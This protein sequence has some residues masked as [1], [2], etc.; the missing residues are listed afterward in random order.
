MNK[1]ALRARNLT[2]VYQKIKGSNKPV[3][4][5]NKL[6]LE[7]EQGEI[8]GLLG[9]NGAG[10]TT[11]VDLM[12]RFY[13]VTSGEI[14]IDGINVKDI[15]SG[16]DSSQGPKGAI[17]KVKASTAKQKRKKGQPIKPLVATGMMRRLPPIK[18]KSG[19][20]TISLA[21]QRVKIAQYHEQGAGNLPKREFFDIYPQ[22]YRKIE[23]MLK[24]KLIKLFS[25]L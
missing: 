12:P 23:R 5:L 7:V 19:K 21:N 16:L 6:N 3:L 25:K 20:S 11:F 4:A 2:K 1:I 24:K 10:K 17:K 22:T 18:N 8:F 9:P 14:T 13:D 15:K